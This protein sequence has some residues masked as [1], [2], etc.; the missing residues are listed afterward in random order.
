MSQQG[1]PK[2]ERL[3]DNALWQEVCS[4]TEYMYSKLH[5]FPEEEK[6]ETERKLRTAA[7]DLMFYAAQAISNAS[8]SLTEFDWGNVRRSAGA[9]KTM[10][11]F[12]CRQKF[13]ELEPEIMVRLS[14]LMKRIEAEVTKA[15]KQTEANNKKDI[16]LWQKRYTMQKAANSEG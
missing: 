15:Y 14:K 2:L 8:P 1:L 9:L 4:L 11:R 3:E 13:I 5:G 10:Y 12:A 7:N 6:W 16:E